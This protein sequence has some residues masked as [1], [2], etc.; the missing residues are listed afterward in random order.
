MRLQPIQADAW[1]KPT[2]QY[3]HPSIKNKEILKNHPELLRYRTCT[4][5][6]LLQHLFIHSALYVSQHIWTTK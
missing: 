1:Q 4:V 5:Q 6:S 2:Q 3:N